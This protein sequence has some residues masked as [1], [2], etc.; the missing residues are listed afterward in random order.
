[1]KCVMVSAVW[2][3]AC[4]IMNKRYSKLKEKFPEWTFKKLDIDFD[5]EVVE[6]L[7]VGK[8]LPVFIVYDEAHH[9]VRRVVGEL[10]EK[11]LEQEVI[12]G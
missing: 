11:Q 12:Y 2:C 3:P 8:T 7:A 10:N 1:M 6:K 4:L 5:E 9:E